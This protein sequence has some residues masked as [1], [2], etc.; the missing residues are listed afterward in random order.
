[1]K[2]TNEERLEFARAHKSAWPGNSIHGSAIIHS[3]ALVGE[4]GFGF[5]R[6][7]DG[8]LIQMPHA[9]GIIIEKDVEIRAFVTVDRGTVQN[10]CIGE[11]TRVD[12]HCH[13]AHNVKIGKHNTFA[14]GCII[15]GSCEI[16]DYNTFGAGVIVQT[17]VKVGNHCI[18]GSGSV[19]TKDV[20][21]YSV[22]VGNPGRLL[23]KLEK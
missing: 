2:Y 21:D 13:I 16:G 17:K 7:E 1:M 15:E 10:T 5:V 23:R 4:D 6:T 8:S 12:H 9:G 3:M 11:G 19:I 18:I 22:I 20:E 14:N